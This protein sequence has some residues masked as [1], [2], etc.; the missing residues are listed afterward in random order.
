MLPIF[1]LILAN[2]HLLAKFGFDTAGLPASQAA[3]NEPRQVCPPPTEARG[4][5]S[6]DASSRTRA[7][8]RSDSRAP[9]LPLEPPPGP[10]PEFPV[11][12]PRKVRIPEGGRRGHDP[13][14]P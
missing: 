5:R 2:E 6:D 3:E 4:E 1:F 9:R 8:A 11:G 12:P 14:A 13:E 7:R 10:R